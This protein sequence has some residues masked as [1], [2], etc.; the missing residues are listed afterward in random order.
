M[1]EEIVVKYNMRAGRIAL[2][3]FGLA[4]CTLMIVF[5]WNTMD[6][7]YTRLNPESFFAGGICGVIFLLWNLRSLCDGKP[8]L[9]TSEDGVFVGESLHCYIPWE[10]VH[11][12]KIRKDYVELRMRSYTVQVLAI[13]LRDPD[14]VFF[15]KLSHRFLR[16]FFYREFPI[17]LV[18][19][20]A[21][22]WT[23]ERLRDALRKR[24]S[25]A[26]NTPATND[27]SDG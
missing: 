2:S 17:D 16:K 5:G 11:D 12:I 3:V 10:N 26:V 13:E 18:P 4:I 6:S 25:E 19:D 21:T 24:W 20:T 9:E 14:N 22:S 1:A 8:F 27:A 7:T 23:S 15:D